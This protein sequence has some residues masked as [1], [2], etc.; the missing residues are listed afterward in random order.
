MFKRT[1]KLRWRRRLRRSKRQV[2]DIGY[3]TEENLEKHLFKRLGRLSSVKRF[4]ISW[5][6]LM[7][8]LAGIILYQTRDLAKFYLS[9]QPTAGG[10]YAEG[11]LGSFTNANPLYAVNN[12]DATVSRLIFAGLFKYDQKNRLVGDLAQS[13]QADKRGT[14]YTVQLKRNLVWQD[15]RPLTASD[16]V[17]T[18]KT[19]QN[20]DA[21][22]PLS[23]SWRNIKIEAP[24]PR[25]VVF[26]LPS[27]LSSFPYALTNGIVPKHLLSGIPTAQLRSVAFNTSAP[28]GAGPFKWEAIEIQGETSEERVQ[29]IALTANENYH[30]GKPKLSGFILNAF[31][32]SKT[33]INSFKKR[34]LNAMVGLNSL[35]EELDNKL[36][37]ADYNI[38]LAG[39]AFVFFKTTNGILGNQEVR[40]AI[41]MATNVHSIIKNLDYPVIRANQPFLK[42]Q[43]GHN[44]K[45]AQLSTNVARA[46]KVLEKDGWKIGKDGI[47]V[48]NKKHLSFKLYSQSNSEYAQVTGEL[49]KQWR[50]IGVDAQ[51]F[52]QPSTEL[53]TTIGFHSYEALLYGITIG[54]DPDVFAYWHSSQ[55]D[56]RSSN[57]LN[58]SEYKSGTADNALEAGRNRQNETVRKVK[59]NQFLR[60]WR[61]DVPAIALY[62]PNFLYITRGEL[63]NFNPKI[64]NVGTDR[65]AN[66][67]NWMINQKKLPK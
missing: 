34:E 57:R 42:G 22:S 53:Q 58:F 65:F 47:R 4:V 20:P 36:S 44:P 3:Q 14:K 1:T 11:M 41:A 25:S 16:V 17:F 23:S 39:Q 50:A 61:S 62:Q 27:A 32:D 33:M 10:T 30:S 51:V 38:P 31:R 48:K 59:Y 9:L 8:L 13:W 43:L 29:R 55:A 7:L 49:Q 37:I 67:E 60:A 6:L 26:K 21:Q 52:L 15:G 40:R 63:F 2:E 12:V 66:V 19:I 24:N 64:L 56:I 45:L 35:P 5:L 28:L 18:Y 54:V 46:K